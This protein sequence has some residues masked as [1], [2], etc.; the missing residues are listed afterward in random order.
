[1][2]Q[3]AYLIHFSGE[4][5]YSLFYKSH[6]NFLK[7]GPSFFSFLQL[8]ALP[9]WVS[10]C[11]RSHTA[12]TAQSWRWA[13]CRHQPAQSQGFA[14]PL[15]GDDTFLASTM[16]SCLLIKKCRQTIRYE[17]NINYSSKLLAHRAKQRLKAN[18]ALTLFV[19]CAVQG[20]A[21]VLIQQTHGEST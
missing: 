13:K 9:A 8:S 3:S 5:A 17:G 6:G 19:C 18:L 11:L 20:S 12:M 15:F 4:V 21:N 16:R 2:Q 10:G 1:M 14:K 7:A